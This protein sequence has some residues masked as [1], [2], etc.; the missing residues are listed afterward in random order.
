MAQ[1]AKIN[2]SYSNIE[3]LF[4]NTEGLLAELASFF[5]RKSRNKEGFM[6][7]QYW[8][9]SVLLSPVPPVMVS[10]GD[11][12]KSNIIT[13]AWTGVL[14]T[15]PP[16]TYISVRRQRHSYEMIKQSGEFVI[17]LASADM[18]QKVDYCGIYTGA[19][20]D[21]FEKCHLT[22]LQSK[23]VGAPTIAEC[24]LSLECRVTDVVPL[25]THDMFVA[26]IVAVSVDE[27]LLDSDGRLCLEKADLLAYAHGEYFSLGESLGKFG[28]SAVKKKSANQSGKKNGNF[29]HRKKQSG[30]EK[31]AST[32]QK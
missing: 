26:D 20:V 21:K 24:K 28:F 14:C 30:K 7:R 27:S 5:G 17:N 3:R 16:K 23:E 29:K 11:M 18:A 22:R 4:S 25:G 9:G 1:N 19:K 12:E 13:I 32:E 8:Q 15:H 6:A 2:D 10:C 31:K